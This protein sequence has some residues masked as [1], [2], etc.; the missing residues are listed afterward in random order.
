MSDSCVQVEYRGHTAIV[1]FNRPDKKNV[2]NRD[3]WT[4]L[5]QAVV[6]LKA[7]LPR[8]IVVTGAEGAFSA[9]FDVNP[10]NPQVTMLLEAI[11]K[12]SRTAVEEV[13]R[14][15]RE[16]TDRLVALPVPIIAA[17]NGMAFG[18]GAELAVRCDM[19][20]MDPGAVICFSE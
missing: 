16:T 15:I 20:V 1:I 10:A 8:A 5:E 6:Q 2:F 3:M 19:R 14:Y 13:V 11:K 4:G 17:I 7:N 9:G 18:G 12:R